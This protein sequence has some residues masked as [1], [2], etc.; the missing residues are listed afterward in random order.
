MHTWSQKF[1]LSIH[2]DSQPCVSRMMAGR[3]LQQS[4]SLNYNMRFYPANDLYK[5]YTRYAVDTWLSPRIKDHTLRR[6][7]SLLNRAMN[8]CETWNTFLDVGAGSGRIS[9]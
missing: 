4:Q 1:L 9:I 6:S 5:F 8:C 3:L 7:I 2:I